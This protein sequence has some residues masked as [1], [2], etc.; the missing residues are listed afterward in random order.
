MITI[1]LTNYDKLVKQVWEIVVDKAIDTG[2]KK[3]IYKLRWEVSKEQVNQ[4]VFDTWLLANSY[5]EQFSKLTWE[6]YN[7][8]K[9]WLYVHEWH[10]QEVWRFVP[11]IWKRLKQSF[12]KGRPWFTDT[13]EKN[14]KL[15]E[16]VIAQE[17]FNIFKKIWV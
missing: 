6:L 15:P 8:R 5:R 9:Y 17:L 3:T 13:L 1:N 7:F 16:E 10:K 4:K 2:I 11:A 14:S 12:I